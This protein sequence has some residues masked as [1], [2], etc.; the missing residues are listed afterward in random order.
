MKARTRKT[1]EST[2]MTWSLAAS[3]V[4][5]VLVVMICATTSVFYPLTGHA[6]KFEF[7]WLAAG[8]L[9]DAADP[10]VPLP[11][12]N[13]QPGGNGSESIQTTTPDD[14]A[15][16]DADQ[17]PSPQPEE[18]DSVT[19]VAAAEK[20][21]LTRNPPAEKANIQIPV[22]P[23]KSEQLPEEN[24]RT[25]P[26]EKQLVAAT[27]NNLR[28]DEEAE[29]AR[30]EAKRQALE[31]AA[32]E[33]RAREELNAKK[34]EQERLATERAE[35]ERIVREQAER[36]RLAAEKAELE[37][38]AA[39]QRAALE[40]Q[41]REKAKQER[42]AAERAER[43]RTTREQAERERL[44][45]EQAERERIATA[46]RAEREQQALEKARQE[47]LASERAERERLA[48]EQAERDRL[49]ADQ[50]ERERKAAARKAALEQQAR[51]KARQE[52]L[53]A[54]RA[55]RER[56][57]REQTERD[58]IATEKAEQERKAAARKAA[59]A[60]QARE[61]ARQERLAAE[62]T[63]RERT[64]REQA[65]RDRIAAERAEQDRKAAAHKAALE[66]QAREKTRQERLAA[67]RTER[68][69]I[70]RE[71]TERDRIAAERA[72]QERKAAA[73]K[74]ALE[75]QEREKA[76]QERLAAE[77]LRVAANS[78]T[79]DRPVQ[80]PDPRA[81]AADNLASATTRQAISE[82]PQDREKRQAAKVAPEAAQPILPPVY[83]DLK[84]VVETENDLKISVLFREVPQSRR[85]RPMTRAEA[86]RTR[87]VEPLVLKTV[88]NSREV[89]IKTAGQGVYLFLAETD[90]GETNRGAFTL[91]VFESTATARVKAIG[92]RTIAGKTVIARV[93]MPEGILWEDDTAFSGS[94]EDSDSTTKF[95]A[96]TGLAWKEYKN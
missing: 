52:R 25:Y 17:D 28:R 37:S 11:A 38:K 33:Q 24:D 4:F 40:Q 1:N 91:K 63:E 79:V 45:A 16:N 50:A 77:R 84:M 53:A 41:A 6:E 90:A 31:Q 18:T 76:R 12:E 26:P 19:L 7:I 65:E 35:L 61:K 68:E 48:R 14:P 43:E 23:R 83:G 62:R 34:L 44:A 32:V 2:N 78:R 93:L 64:T 70:A 20:I 86:T 71:Q 94:Y 66:Q 59:L 42:L 3:I 75:Q 57:A 55:E 10:S 89:I 92:N 60:Q 58:R 72:E 22:Q 80:K 87:K 13:G 81:G 29:R 56:I 21:P 85:S 95:N 5:H 15:E 96:D 46:Q 54:E 67:E 27:S 8:S 51:E 73:H 9:P 30:E 82:L 74:S 36:D 88:R 69:R 49:A 47:R 39:A